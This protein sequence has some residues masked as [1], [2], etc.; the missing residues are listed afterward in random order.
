MI[1]EQT[2]KLNAQEDETQSL[3]QSLVNVMARLGMN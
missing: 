3:R 1:A 2:V